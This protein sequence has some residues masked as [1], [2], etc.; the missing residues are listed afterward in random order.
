[1][2]TFMLTL[3]AIIME[4]LLIIYG[5]VS[6]AYLFGISSFIL[7]MYS[8]F[9]INKEYVGKRLIILSSLSA[10]CAIFRILFAPITIV[11]PTLAIIIAMSSFV[12]PLEAFIM[13][14]I[15]SVIANMFLG[16]GLWT[17]YQMFAFGIAGL[18]SSLFIKNV[19][20]LWLLIFGILDAALFCFIINISSFII[21]S[22]YVSF[23]LFINYF[24]LSLPYDILLL[25]STCI[26]LILFYNR[27][28]NNIKINSS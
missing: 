9:E 16:Q 12:S 26:F 6:M 21:Y 13:S 28:R 5:N 17:V 8:K 27:L 1:M 2:E 25:V 11:R 10:V 23:D 20:L 19:K 18:L 7:I 22:K 24:A 3:I 15:S 4:I 14:S